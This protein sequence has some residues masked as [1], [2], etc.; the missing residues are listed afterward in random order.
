MAAAV[1]AVR[2]AK[3][4]LRKRLKSALA[5]MSDLQKREECETLTKKVGKGKTIVAPYSACS[6]LTWEIHW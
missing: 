6:T 3:H 1:S 4:E 2:A 5:A